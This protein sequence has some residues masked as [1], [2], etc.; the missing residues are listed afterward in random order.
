VIGKPSTD[1]AGLKEASKLDGSGQNVDIVQKTIRQKVAKNINTEGVG[2]GK[3]IR[4][5]ATVNEKALETRESKTKQSAAV[6]DDDQKE[7]GMHWKS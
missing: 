2:D 6:Y 7:I 5:S 3:L 4:S 1:Q